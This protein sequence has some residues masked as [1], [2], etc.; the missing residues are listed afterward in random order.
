MTRQ[1][2]RAMFEQG[3]SVDEIARNRNLS[4]FTIIRHL[5]ELLE[6]GEQIAIARL[7]DPERYEVI[8]DALRQVDSNLLRPVKDFLGDDYSYE[9]IRM[10]SAAMRRAE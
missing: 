1:V 5:T 8:A 6:D 9:E 10:V 3:L 7:I 2:T 4:R